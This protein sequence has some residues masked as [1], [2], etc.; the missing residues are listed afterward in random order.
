M[1]GVVLA[2]LYSLSGC[3]E[4]RQPWLLTNIDYSFQ[5]IDSSLPTDA[6]MDE[7]IA[8]YRDSVDQVMGKIIGESEIVMVKGFP[9]STLGN[10]VCNLLLDSCRKSGYQVDFAMNN[11]GGLRAILPKGDISRSNVFELMP[12]DNWVVVVEMDAAH[13]RQLMEYIPE[14]EDI[15]VSGLRIEIT[16][17]VAKIVSIQGEPFD[18]TRHYFMV[19]NDYLAQGGS[20]MGFLK[21]A[22]VTDTKV[23]VRDMIEG[24][25]NNRYKQGKRINAI[26]DGRIK[27]VE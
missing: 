26:T 13:M 14:G 11:N 16:D 2:L 19:T 6:H 1:Y 18:S 9:E 10:F 17:K 12:F 24:Y 22:P 23:L 3:R 15:A 8:H 25:I 5:S 27:I 4:D 20:H 21:D 7:M